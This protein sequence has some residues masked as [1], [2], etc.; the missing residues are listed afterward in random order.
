MPSKKIAAE[1]NFPAEHPPP[2]VVREYDEGSDKAAVEELERR[3]EVGP[4]GKPSLVT[5]LMGDPI[6]RVRNFV[7]HIMLVAE[8][9][10]GGEIVGVIRG[11]IKTVTS[12]KKISSTEFPVYVKL[13]YILGL[14]VSSTHRRLGIAT[15]L[16]QELENW[17]TKNGAE[18]SYMATERANQP[19]LNLFIKKCNYVKFRNPTVL[20]QPVHLHQKP[21]PSDITIVRIPPNISEQ[22]YQTLFSCSEF[23]PKDIDKLLN[24]KLSLGTFMALPKNSH[25][26]WNTKNAGDLLPKSSFAILSIW[27]TKEV[28]RLQ[29]KGVS[30]VTHAACVGT[31]V[32]DAMVPWLKIPSI[33]NVFENFGFYFMYGLHMEGNDGS[34]LMRNLCKFVH[35]M[36]QDDVDIRVLVAEVAPMDRVREAV[37]HWK[38]FSWEEDIWCIKRLGV[39]VDENNCHDHWYKSSDSSEVIFVDPREL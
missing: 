3:C 6:A 24:N 2:L 10:D 14:R 38:R 21:L 12:G 37:P 39:Q 8:Y 33:P 25:S 7:S 35:N 26:K 16:V 27:N 30:A 1:A 15:K 22:I 11:C 23:F 34:R 31:R 13:A 9:G 36:A 17:S 28:Y 32:L 29:M 5:D 20:V 4:P 19:S 18:Y